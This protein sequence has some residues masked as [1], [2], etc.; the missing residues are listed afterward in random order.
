[1][2]N[3]KI[4]FRGVSARF[5]LPVSIEGWLVT[6]LFFAGLMAIQA[7]NQPAAGTPLTLLQIV[8]IIAQFALLMAGLARLTKGHVDKRY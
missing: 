7:L 4:W 5:W 1:M 6:A 3:K 2:S 8:L